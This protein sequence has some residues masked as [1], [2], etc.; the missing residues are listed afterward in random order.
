[1]T[2]NEVVGLIKK[3]ATAPWNE[4]ST[5]DRFKAGNPDTTVKGIATTMMTT[6]DMLKRAHAAGL[7]M[8]ITH[9]DTYWNDPDDT[10]DL[11]ANALYKLKTEYILKNDMVVWRDHDNMHAT[12]PDY[13]VVGELRSAGIKGGGNATMRPG[14]LT[15]PETTFGE[16]AEQVKRSSG[17]RAIRCVGDPKARVSKVLVGPGYATPRMTPEV[18]VVIGGEQQ[19]ADGG[20][21]NVEYV[22][23]AVSLGMAKGVIML[24]HV[25]SE[26]AGMEDFGKWIGIFIHGIPIQFVPAEEP[27]W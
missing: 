1:M 2:A 15:I 24:G 6:F 23:D 7:N 5:R 14:V 10:K 4:R 13:T 16:F 25:I 20:F 21:D 12:K 19:E 27:F 17:A 22:M 11:T 3:N 26:Q 18:D 9:E 8:V